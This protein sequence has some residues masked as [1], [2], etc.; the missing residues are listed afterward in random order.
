MEVDANYL[1]RDGGLLTPRF[2]DR[3]ACRAA[4]DRPLSASLFLSC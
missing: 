2:T 4:L 3:P 1:Q